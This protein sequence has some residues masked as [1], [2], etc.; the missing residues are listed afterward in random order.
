MERV[1][2]VEGAQRVRFDYDAADAA[3]T[4]ASSGMPTAV[5]EQVGT[6]ATAVEAAKEDWEGYY[7][8]EF[9]R[10]SANL[11]SRLDLVVGGDITVVSAVYTAV[12]EANR[13]QR[14]YNQTALDA[15]EEAEEADAP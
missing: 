2:P 1:A 6:Y 12:N 4:W 8:R 13:R 9:D 10:A 5:S 15:A 11:R 3:L 7:R 14:Q